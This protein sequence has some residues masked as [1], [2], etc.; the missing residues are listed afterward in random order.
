MQQNMLKSVVS[1]I[2]SLES[3][4]LSL[5]LEMPLTILDFERLIKLVV[6]ALNSQN[7][8]CA[9]ISLFARGNMLITPA[10]PVRDMNGNRTMPLVNLIAGM[11]VKVRIPRHRKGN[12]DTRRTLGLD[13]E[14][15]DL[16]TGL[17][18]FVLSGRPMTITIRLITDVIHRSIL[19]EQTTRNNLGGKRTR[20]G[21][22]RGNENRSS[23]R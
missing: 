2:S 14:I 17:K 10:G 6:Q 13:D 4:P 19:L 1:A 7:S 20:R 12:G 15:R 23:V 5:G 18:Q 8:T 11:A 9:R 22:K 21:F 16:I 3:F